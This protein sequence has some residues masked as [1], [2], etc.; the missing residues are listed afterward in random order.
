MEQER[1]RI[2]RKALHLFFKKGFSRV[3]TQDIASSLGISKKTLYRHFSSKRE[4]ALEALSENL[5]GIGGRL[6]RLFENREL[7]FGTR[8]VTFM[9]LVN[10]QIRS[11]G[12][13]FIE[14][15]HRSLPEAWE[16]IDTFRR[17]RVFAFLRRLLL[18]GRE[19]G[20]VREELSVE[21][22]V[23]LITGF[24]NQVLVPDK[25]VDAGFSLQQVFSTI[26]E[27]LYGGILTR[28]GYEE[29]S[30]KGKRVK[31]EDLDGG[32]TLFIH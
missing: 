5:E 23:F 6:D 7:D 3:T 19:R 27:L 13:L 17:E 12:D 10:R 25:L 15:I 11:I 1:T 28:E 26:I 31:M 9:S 16:M 8:F 20:F 22:L 24:I 4:I 32:N 18:E 30:G 21:E 14:D 2:L 29:V